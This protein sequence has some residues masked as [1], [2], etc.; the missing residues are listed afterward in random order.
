MITV[1]NPAC[2]VDIFSDRWPAN[3]TEQKLFLDD[4]TDFS[5]RLARLS[6]KVDLVEM[7]SILSDLFGENPSHQVVADF[8]DRLGASIDAGKLRYR[9]K[10]GSIDIIGSGLVTATALVPATTSSRHSR[11]HSFYGEK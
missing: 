10:D 9:P 1:T 5:A 3:L 4:L 6:S 7:K 8:N 11:P 2:Q